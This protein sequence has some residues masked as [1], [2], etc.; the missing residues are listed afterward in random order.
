MLLG[1]HHMLPGGW[2]TRMWAPAAQLYPVPETMPDRRAVL[3]E[4][5]AVV[6][7]GL[8]QVRWDTVERALVLGAGPIGLLTVWAIGETHPAVHLHAAARYPRQGRLAALLGTE[9][10][11]DGDPERWEPTVL[12]MSTPGMW[13]GGTWHSAGFDLVVDTVGSEL[14]VG[15]SLRWARPGGQVLL[16][17]GAGT[18]RLDLAPLW[19][20][21]LTWIGT[22][23][24]AYRG[25]PAFPVALELLAATRRPVEAIIGDV[26]PLDDYRH[27]LPRFWRRRHEA[28][29]LV[30][31]APDY[32]PR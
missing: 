13:G 24:Y 21:N 11:T 3:A 29:K 20:R 1:Y 22:Y 2:S 8:D 16:I 17:G 7:H 9:E 27:A 14:T 25:R 12:G 23:G 4:P 10:V 6:L 19:S 26:A 30:L 5:T 28:I 31:A 18:G 15:Q 32:R